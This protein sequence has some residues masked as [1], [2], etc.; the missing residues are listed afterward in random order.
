MGRIVGGVVA[1]YAVMAVSVFALFSVAYFLLGADGAFRP[2]SWEMSATWLG[3]S[4]AIGILAGIAGGYICAAVGRNP[5]ATKAL[6][7]VVVLLG[8]VSAIP[9]FTGS[10]EATAAARAGA[11]GMFEAMQNAQEPVWIALLN[12]VL[13]VIGVLIGSRLRSRR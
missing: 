6:I 13:G 10:P 7:T 3:L 8:I 5:T 9:A 4:I 1:G 11:V 2:A 12:P